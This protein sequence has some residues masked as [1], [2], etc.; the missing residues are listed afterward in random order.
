MPRPLSHHRILA[1]AEPFARRGWRVD[2]TACDRAAGRLV[3]RRDDATLEVA[4]A[5]DGERLLRRETTRDGLQAVFELRGRDEAAL[6]AALDALPP[7][8]QWLEGPGYVAALSHAA[9]DAGPPRPVK[10][11]LRVGPVRLAMTP[12]G[13]SARIELR[14]P[15]QPPDDLLAVQGWAWSPLLPFG[16]AWRASVRM[17]RGL[18]HRLQQAA[19]HLARTLA[20]PPAAFHARFAAARWRVL[21]RRSIPLALWHA[22][23]L[24][25]AFA[26]QLRDAR[27]TIAPLVA[28]LVPP[29]L[30]GLFAVTAESPRLEIPPAPRP[31]DE[32]AW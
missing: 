21:A 26:P 10:G 17:G 1:V 18:E 30:L 28:L 6:L 19:R 27:D 31:L 11:E 5:A 22:V 23:I 16:T 15:G 9:R 8:A 25:A 2:L 12:G 13:R 29:A 7:A 14:T 3:L 20:E 24:I 32:A 4:E